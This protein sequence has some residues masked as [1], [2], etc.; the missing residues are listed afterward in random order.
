MSELYLER[1]EAVTRF[2][3]MMIKQTDEAICVAWLMQQ[4]QEKEAELE[5][6]IMV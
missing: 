3:S 1:M 4:Y 2:H 6:T 5:K